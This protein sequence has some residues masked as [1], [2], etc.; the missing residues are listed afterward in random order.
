[1]KGMRFSEKVQGIEISGIRRIF[2]GAGPGSIN[3]GLG[4]PDFDTPKHIKDAAV[5]AIAEGKTGYTVNAGIPELRTAICE[6]LRRENALS[7]RPEQVIVTAGASEALHLVCQTLVNPGD[8]VLVPDPGFVSY[9]ALATIAGAKV[10]GIPPHLDAP[11]RRRCREGADGRGEA[12]LPEQPR[13]P[14]GGRGEPGVHLRP[15]RVRGRPRGDR[16]L[17]RGV[18]ALHLREAPRERRLLRGERHHRERGVKDLCDDGVADR[19]PRRR[20]ERHRP[21][22]EGPPVLPGLRHLHRPVRGPRGLYRRPVLGRGD[23]PRVPGPQGPPLRGAEQA[24]VPVP[25]PRGGLLYL[26]P[27]GEGSHRE[28]DQEGGHHRPRGLLRPER[29]GLCP[30]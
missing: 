24:R 19:L 13:E 29:T 20:R 8:R 22:H 6:K 15:R 23:A 18:R 16:G 5:R 3:L 28:G 2:E 21:V 25:R 30:A 10:E 17:R 12:P 1:M 9:A 14:D 11:H 7:Y 26:R 27:P 4:Q